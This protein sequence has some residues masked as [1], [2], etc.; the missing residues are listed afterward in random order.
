VRRPGM[1]IFEEAPLVWWSFGMDSKD[2]ILN[3][4]GTKLERCLL[5]GVWLN[6]LDH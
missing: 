2:E 3:L 4:L 1:E 5:R 6:V